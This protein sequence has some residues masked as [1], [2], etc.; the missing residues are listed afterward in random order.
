[1]NKSS[2]SQLDY[3]KL[4]L[5]KGGGKYSNLDLWLRKW[6]WNHTDQSKLR[7][8]KDGFKYV[9]GVGFPIFRVK[10]PAKLKNRTLI[11][12]SR[13]ITCCYYIENLQAIWLTGKDE[14]VMLKLHADNLQQYLDNQ[15]LTKD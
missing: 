8:S 7:L 1:M 14:T 12:M 11:Q 4:F 9:R 3:A 2:L 5:E 6:F 13:L 10:L 15:D